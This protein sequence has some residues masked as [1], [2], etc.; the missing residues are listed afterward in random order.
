MNVVSELEALQKQF[1]SKCGELY[2][3]IEV[4]GDELYKEMLHD[5]LETYKDERERLKANAKNYYAETDYVI[6][7][8]KNRLTPHNCGLF[9][10][11]KNQMKK[12]I[13]HETDAEIRSIFDMRTNA[14]EELEEKLKQADK[15]DPREVL[16]EQKP[17]HALFRKKQ[18]TTAPPADDQS[19]AQSTPASPPVVPTQET[20][21]PQKKRGRKPKANTGEPLQGQLRIE[22]TTDV[23][24][25]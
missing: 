16:F 18:P 3:A 23:K 7:I 25:E 20:P 10:L 1:Y 9:W 2:E 5:Y 4:L 22:L 19:G 21:Q 13:N 24:T 15:T 14:V 17:K 8:K 11:K 12:M 6:R